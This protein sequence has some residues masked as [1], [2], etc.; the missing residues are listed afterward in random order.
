M[1]IP[2]II[3]D[4]VPTCPA[5]YGL[6]PDGTQCLPITAPVSV[7]TTGLSLPEIDPVQAARLSARGV[8]DSGLIERAIVA[9]ASSA[10]NLIASLFALAATSFDLYFSA[11]G[12][13][14]ILA[15]GQ[16][17]AGYYEL[18]AALMTDLLG[19]EVD[20]AQLF[21]EFKAKGRVAS[22]TKVG[23]AFFNALA[24]ESA[25]IEQ[26]DAGSAWKT[27][28]GQGV[29]GLPVHDFQPGEGVKA[30]QAMLGFAM[31]F[32]V[33]EGNT[34]ALASLLNIHGWNLGE[35]FKDFAEDF[36]KS[37]GLSRLLR[38]AIRPL[39]QIM[40][41]LPLQYDLHRQYRPT[42]LGV[43]DAIRAWKI[44]AFSD[45]DL[46]AEFQMHGF[47]DARIKAMTA[48]KSKAL[49]IHE[50]RTALAATGKTLPA[51]F[52][53]EDI[54]AARLAVDQYDLPTVQGWNIVL[55]HDPARKLSLTYVDH[56]VFQFLTGHITTEGIKAFLDQAQ[57]AA[58]VLLT[59]GEFAAMR[60]LVDSVSANPVLRIR[61][62][63]YATLQLAYID[64]TISLTEL[65]DHL[66]L[67]G[68]A[69]ND[70]TILVLETLFKAKHKETVAATKAA[71]KKPGASTPGS[72][73]PGIGG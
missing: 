70:V 51:G 59:A 56:Y 2:P 29:G 69:E 8:A 66:R 65:E 3:L 53:T 67:L 49:S 60:A 20:G 61:H 58:G 57:S 25:G 52:M 19:I 43:T 71:K 27:S 33:R 18:I 34:D 35:M 38:I 14:F 30:A 54:M 22:M 9:W 12:K 15:Q 16:R 47:S 11:L 13:F 31:S 7:T 42:L 73:L 72:V 6:S 62:L 23:G 41:A 1:S 10:W 21:A 45:A 44:G 68:Y 28:P 40:V 5:G 55:D 26:V 17:T 39:F 4:G 48:D 50:Y 24:S 64:G 37:V 32:A 36:S 63:P 46:A